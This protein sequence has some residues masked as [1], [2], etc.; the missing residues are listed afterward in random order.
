MNAPPNYQAQLAMSQP[1]AHAMPEDDGIDLAE[2]WDILIDSRWL[3]VG[4]TA[5]AIAA[6]GA[7]AFL[8][9][10]VY[11]S[12]LLIQVE[13]SGGAKSLLGDAA[14]LF[15]TKTAASAEIEILRSRM[16]LGQAVDNTLAYVEATPRYL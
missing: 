2:Y 12:N 8:T 10:P 11:Q 5:L 14:D 13:D 1:T 6:G 15:A 9:S 16:V 4:I 7:Y 3:I